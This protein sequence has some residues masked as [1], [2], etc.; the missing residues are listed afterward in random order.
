MRSSPRPSCRQPDWWLLQPP[1]EAS[2]KYLFG[3]V[4]V[5]GESNNSIIFGTLTLRGQDVTLSLTSPPITSRTHTRSSAFPTPMIRRSSRLLLPGIWRSMVRS[6][7]MAKTSSKRICIYEMGE[8]RC[9]SDCSLSPSS[10]VL[11]VN[12]FRLLYLFSG[13]FVTYIFAYSYSYCG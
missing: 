5:L 11:E 2:R 10:R 8:R 7:L 9:V 13:F 12:L 1:R 6:G 3:S 4:G